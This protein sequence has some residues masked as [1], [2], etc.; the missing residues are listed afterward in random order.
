[1]ERK[2]VTSGSSQLKFNCRQN[3]F[4]SDG[5]RSPTEKTCCRSAFSANSQ[6]EINMKNI[7]SLSSCRAS[8]RDCLQICS[9]IENT[10][11]LFIQPHVRKEKSQLQISGF[12]SESVKKS[13]SDQI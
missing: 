3:E 8:D 12:I 9:M 11:S 6:S 2:A 4:V 1:M 7:F 10:V 5:W 13:S